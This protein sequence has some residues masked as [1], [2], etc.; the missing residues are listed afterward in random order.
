MTFQATS[1]HLIILLGVPAK[2]SDAALALHS[3]FGAF[4]PSRYRVL[5][6]VS[7]CRVQS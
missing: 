5:S 6:E 7:R 2:R 3:A 4:P 1:K